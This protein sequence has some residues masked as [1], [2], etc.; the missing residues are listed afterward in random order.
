MS[1]PEKSLSGCLWKASPYDE[2]QAAV[3]SQRHGLSPLV[4]AIIAARGISVDGVSSFIAPKLQT[5]MP[6]PSVM[7]DV[8]KAAEKIAEAV[9]GGRKIGIIG[10][11]DVDGATSSSVLRLFLESVGCNPSVHIP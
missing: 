1:D 6:D 11:Y 4:A 10:D 9:I 7:K 8:D 3:I 5:L 2:R